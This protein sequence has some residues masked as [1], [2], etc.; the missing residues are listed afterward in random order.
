MKR[1]ADHKPQRLPPWLHRPLPAG[2]SYNHTKNVLSSLGLETICTNAN[3]P[4]RGECWTRGTATVLILGRLCTRSCRF[5]SVA[6]GKPK[7]PDPTEPAQ[8]AEMAKQLAL[9]YLV[10]TSVNRDD[11]PD[12]G[13]GHFRDCVSEV[14]L[15]CQG[16]KF[17]ILTPDFRNCQAE[18]IKILADTL[19]FVF[20][21]NVE[22]VASLYPTARASGNYQRSL[23]LLKMFFGLH[24]FGNHG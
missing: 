7:P 20:A 23:N 5:C 14:R 21:H 3:C 16:I 10:I 19:P 8:I 12:G 13:A 9:K 1:N 22:T 15:Q 17:E 11:L 6:T 24:F 18:A 2:E 4:N